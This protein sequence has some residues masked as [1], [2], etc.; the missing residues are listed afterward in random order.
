MFTVLRSQKGPTFPLLGTDKHTE[1]PKRHLPWLQLAML[2]GKVMNVSGDDS[3]I[4]MS[5]A[6]QRHTE[7]WARLC[8]KT[9]SS[10]TRY[11]VVYEAQNE[12]TSP[13][14]NGQEPRTGRRRSTHLEYNSLLFPRPSGFAALPNNKWAHSS[15]NLAHT[16]NTAMS[17]PL[18]LGSRR[19]S[20]HQQL[21]AKEKKEKKR[22]VHGGRDATVGLSSLHPKQLWWQGLAFASLNM[23]SAIWL[24]FFIV[25]LNSV[26]KGQ[27]VSVSR[28]QTPE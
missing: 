5:A 3:K 22:M 28:W 26:P 4:R 2:S 17:P 12:S 27:A 21:A 16:T 1:Q 14:M 23:C 9:A 11:A 25:P 15:P 13:G 8:T 18:Q 7:R 10:M 20:K 19:Q 24:F 6:A